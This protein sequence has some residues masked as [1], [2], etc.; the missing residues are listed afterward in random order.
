[1]I[2]WFGTAMLCYVTPREHLGLPDRDDVKVGVVTYKLAAHTADLAKGHPAAKLRDDALSRSRFEFRWRDQFNLSLD[3][4]T[5][6]QSQD[7]TGMFLIDALLVAGAAWMVRQV[8]TG[9]W[10]TPDPAATITEITRTAGGA[11]GIVT[12]LLLVAFVV[13]RGRGD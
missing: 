4:D 9:T 8:Q 12:A 10:N 11:I 3:P 7:Q 5:A 6:E 2:G 13:H 1:M